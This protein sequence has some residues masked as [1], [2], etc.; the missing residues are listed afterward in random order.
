MERRATGKVEAEKLDEETRISIDTGGVELAFLVVVGRLL[1]R[2]SSALGAFFDG[3]DKTDHAAE[4]GQKGL[5]YVCRR[6]QLN[7]LAAP[8]NLG[9]VHGSPFLK[10]V[11]RNFTKTWAWKLN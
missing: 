1:V 8:I 4:V 6:V 5:I 11:K 9:R 10:A 7:S 2:W 3:L